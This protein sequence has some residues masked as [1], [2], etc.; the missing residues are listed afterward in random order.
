MIRVCD[1]DV[2]NLV[3]GLLTPLL[4]EAQRFHSPARATDGRALMLLDVLGVATRA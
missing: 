3:H 1:L 4:D 2:L